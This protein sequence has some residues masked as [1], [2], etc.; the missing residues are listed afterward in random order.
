MLQRM[1]LCA[2]THRLE[3]CTFSRFPA[4]GA[5]CVLVLCVLP[6]LLCV[7]R[8]QSVL[9]H[10]AGDEARVTGQLAKKEKLARK[11]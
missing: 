3:M 1:C 4:L 10:A 9:N 6:H 7:D 8:P 2:T 11:K 5:E